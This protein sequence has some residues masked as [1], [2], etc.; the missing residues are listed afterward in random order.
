MLFAGQPWGSKLHGHTRYGSRWFHCRAG[1]GKAPG[2]IRNQAADH[3]TI[4]IATPCAWRPVAWLRGTNSQSKHKDVSAELF[5]TFRK[6]TRDG[7]V[8][9]QGV[10]RVGGFVAKGWLDPSYQ[11]RIGPPDQIRKGPFLIL[12]RPV[13][14]AVGL[15]NAQ[16]EPC[17]KNWCLATT[18]PLVARTFHG[19]MCFCDPGWPHLGFLRGEAGESAKYPGEM[20]RL[21]HPQAAPSAWSHGASFRSY[22][23]RGP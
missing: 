11:W 19:K 9:F 20:C 4:W 1:C 2:A 13:G 10:L 18:R 8:V 23:A 16:G 15:G 14:C 5:G 21:R 12:V 6:L 17:S 7:V 22:P 3:V